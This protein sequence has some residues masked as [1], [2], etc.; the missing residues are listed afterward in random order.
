MADRA[1]TI[2]L[3]AKESI[4]ESLSNSAY[5]IWFENAGTEGMEE[6]NTF[7][8]SVPNDFAKSKIETRF[9]P[10]IEDSLQE[11]V[12]EE[13]PVRVVVAPLATDGGSPPRSLPLPRIEV[14]EPTVIG[15]LNPKYTFESFVIGSSNRF[16]HAAALAVAEVPARAYNP[17]F[18]YGG[19][20]LGKTHLLQAI[21]HYVATNNPELSVK[22]M[23]VESFTNDFINSVRDRKMEDFK[24]KYRNNDVL[25]I[26]DIQFLENKEGTQEEFF[27]TFNDLYEAGKQ[28]A[29]SSDRPP[30]EIATLEERLRSRFE[31]GLITDIQPPDVETR[32]AILRK[33]VASRNIYISPDSTDE[34]L[35]FIARGIPTNIRELEGALIRVAAQAKFTSSEITLPLA[36]D[37]LKDILPTNLD[38][39]I[40][41]D[42]IQNEACRFF[43]VSMSDLKGSKRSQ[44]IVFPRQIAMY[45]CRELTDSSLPRI[46]EKFGGRDHT[47]VIHA[48][49]KIAKL[50]KEE[51][52]VFTM[53]QQITSRLKNSSR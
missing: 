52:E 37:A 4:R 7:L 1:E 8:L 16:A 41:I 3:R 33:Q 39:R 34:V 45:L 23:T 51:R 24:R 17:F 53:V 19:V 11:V 25:L 6:D 26:D 32:I 29:I 44:S 21:G 47:T 31:S 43:S 5:E 22:Y 28:I 12:G 13:V 15:N 35:G 42:M 20:G 9:M 27:H 18:I 2:W 48:I 46:G 50:I 36:K 40:T 14:S 30:K 38:T 49:N 10:L